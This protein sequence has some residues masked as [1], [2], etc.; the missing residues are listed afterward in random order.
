[1]N[2]IICNQILQP[3]TKISYLDLSVNYCSKCNLYINGNSKDEVIKKVSNLYKKEYWN[4]NNS[5]ISINS[6]YTDVNSEGKRRNWISQFAYTKHHITGNTFLEIGV[7]AG[8]SIVWFEEE[9]FKVKGIEPD[10][11]NV[12]MINKKLK[13]GKVIESSVEDFS[14]DEVFDVVWMSHVLEH[15]IEPINFLKKIKQNLKKNSILFIEVPN[16]DHK[17]TL[18]SSIERNPH[19][20][21]FTKKSL[22]CIVESLGYQIISCDVFR[23]ATKSEGIKQRIFK[24]TYQFY[25]RI[26]T[27]IHSGRDLRLILK[28]S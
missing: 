23:P 19:L 12:D 13:K 4:G 3:Y 27:D 26:L 18:K 14:T 10:G 20:F 24:N 22:T 2:C 16:C 11:R 9:G 1:M 25:P 21:H 15:L 28:N 8:Q 5:E 17:P 7:G 6:G